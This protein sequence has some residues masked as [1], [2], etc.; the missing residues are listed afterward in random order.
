MTTFDAAMA[1]RKARR[2]RLES[3]RSGGNFLYL[4]STNHWAVTHGGHTLNMLM[5]DG[6]V[7]TFE[8]FN[9][10]GF[11]NPGFP[12]PTSLTDL[13]FGRTGYRD[14]TVELPLTG[15]L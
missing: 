11:I 15:V 6:S 8:D 13:Q 10:D 9:R 14:D 12:V 1:T 4:Q 7:Q 5:G 3:N 2:K